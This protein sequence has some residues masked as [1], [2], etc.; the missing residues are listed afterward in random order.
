[1]KDEGGGGGGHGGGGG[2]G[3]EEPRGEGRWK[4]LRKNAK[5]GV[6]G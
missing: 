6:A 3:G 2:G 5:Y 4:K 1:M